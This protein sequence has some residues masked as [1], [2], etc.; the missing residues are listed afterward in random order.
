MLGFGKATYKGFGNN[1]GSLP[2]TPTQPVSILSPVSVPQ[3]NPPGIGNPAMSPTNP[4][5]PPTTP[6][7]PV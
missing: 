6:A 2:T 5:T 7:V 4:Q 1:G 3:S